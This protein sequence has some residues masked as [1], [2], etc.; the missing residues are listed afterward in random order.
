[1]KL[2][3]H[4]HSCFELRTAEG[5]AVLDPYAPGSVPGLALPPL[6]A[7]LVLCS[8]GHRD[9]GCR[10]AVRLSGKRPTFAVTAIPSFHDER[11][12]K[13]RGEN[14]IHVIEAEGL[15]IAHLG[16]LGHMLEQE[17]RAALGTPD[18]LL[19]PV[20]GYYTIGAETA[21]RLAKA[22]GAR[23]TVPMHYRGEGFG[24][25]E[26]GPVEE[27]TRRMD[28][29][30]HADTNELDLTETPAGVTVLRCPGA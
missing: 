29:V 6:T 27:F 16:D 22:V 13:L 4:G 10:E 17:Q 5:S 7:D 1:M 8:H 20:G 14:T 21:A 11:G 18:L 15:R 19:I 24:Y 28:G 12:G 9:H 25:A 30:R 2:I 23:V 26:I 3:W